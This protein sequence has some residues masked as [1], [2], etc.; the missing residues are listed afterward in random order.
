M[1]SHLHVDDEIETIQSVSFEEIVDFL[2]STG[3]TKPCEACGNDGWSVNMK[4]GKP[5]ISMLPV[6]GSSDA[7][8]TFLVMCKRCGNLRMPGAKF[9]AKAVLARR[10]Q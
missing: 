8:L 9:I 2:T 3:A 10:K 5:V 4:D 7:T 1:S 6:L